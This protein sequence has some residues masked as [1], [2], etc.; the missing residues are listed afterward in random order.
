VFIAIRCTG[1]SKS[2]L[3][4]QAPIAARFWKCGIGPCS[5]MHFRLLFSRA[6]I[7]LFSKFIYN[8]P[9][10]IHPQLTINILLVFPS[11]PGIPPISSLSINADR[12]IYTK[13]PCADRYTQ[14]TSKIV[15]L[16]HCDVK[17]LLDDIMPAKSCD[18]DWTIINT[19]TLLHILPTNTNNLYEPNKKT[20]SAHLVDLQL[21]G[22]AAAARIGTDSR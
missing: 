19:S 8:L 21:C 4:P 17:I 22:G 1:C 14:I 18:A 2:R 5:W 10:R 11:P 6:D 7:F 20:R 16:Q 13:Y 15:R 12:S 9:V 3:L